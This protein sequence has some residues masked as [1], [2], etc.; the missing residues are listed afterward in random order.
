MTR[1]DGAKDIVVRFDSLTDMH[2]SIG[3]HGRRMAEQEYRYGWSGSAKTIPEAC[4]QSLSSNRYAEQI[5]A[6]SGR[7]VSMVQASLHDTEHSLD[8]TGLGY[9]IG[10]LMSGV[11]ECWITETP[12]KEP[13]VVRVL[14]N[15]GASSAIG[16]SELILRGVAIAAMVQIL[17]LSGIS[18]EVTIAS[19]IPTSDKKIVEQYTLLKQ[20][21]EYFDLERFAWSIC[22]PAYFRMLHFAVIWEMSGS[23]SGYL[24]APQEVASESYDMYFK[25]SHSWDSDFRNEETIRQWVIAKCREFGVEIGA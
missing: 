20:Q 2:A 12:A 11:P 10:L 16:E 22:D 6:V 4:R 14:V 7:L 9:D 17:E 5:N 24:P 3:E 8:V 23:H 25:K 13:R 1:R 21:G 15:N 19:R 18:T